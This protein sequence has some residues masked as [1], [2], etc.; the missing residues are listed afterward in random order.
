M[1]TDEAEPTS[2]APSALEADLGTLTDEQWLADHR[3]LIA[4]GAIPAG[5][6]AYLYDP[7][8]DPADVQVDEL[9]TASDRK[10]PGRG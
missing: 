9:T 3:A 6:L 4:T 5:E 7:D 2:D 1:T 10:E 8:R